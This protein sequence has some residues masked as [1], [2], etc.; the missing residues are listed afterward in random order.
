M[1]SDKKTFNEYLQFDKR[2]FAIPLFQRK[3]SWQREQAQQLFNDMK[4]LQNRGEHFCGS[5]VYVSDGRDD[6]NQRHVIID[7]QQRLTTVSLMYFALYSLWKEVDTETAE[8]D[9]LYRH[10]RIRPLGDEGIKFDHI[11]DDKII[12]T[13]IINERRRH[14]NTNFYQRLIIQVQVDGMK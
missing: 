6:S 12:Y 10:I 11:P 13:D 1:T 8:M 4:N 14:P 7:G 5:V 2:R 9:I 3:Y